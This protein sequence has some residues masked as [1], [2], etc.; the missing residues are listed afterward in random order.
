MPLYL[1]G[2]FSATPAFRESHDRSPHVLIF[3]QRTLWHVRAD[4]RDHSHLA[5][6]ASFSL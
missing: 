1:S 4:Q 6:T 2:S 3:V 5:L